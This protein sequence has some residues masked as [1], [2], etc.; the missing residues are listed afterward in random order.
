MSGDFKTA[1]IIVLYYPDAV[2]LAE[3]VEAVLPAAAQVILADNTPPADYTE[4]LPL[5][6]CLRINMGGNAGI[7]A[8]QAEALLLA[9]EIG[10]T[11]V[12]MLDQDSCVQPG[13]LEAME[14]EYQRLEAS[15]AS[16]FALGATIVNSRSGAADKALFDKGKSRADGFTERRQLISSGSLI[17]MVAVRETGLPERGL[18][19]DYVDFEWCWRAAIFGFKCFTTSKV[20]L[21]HTVGC[22]DIE[23]GAYRWVISAPERYFYQFR[24]YF[25]LRRRDYVPMGWKWRTFLRMFFYFTYLP[26]GRRRAMSYWRNMWLGACA[27]LK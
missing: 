2:A 26:W 7:A 9:A 18:F 13:F 8:A 1:V 17:N 19:I 10:A 25:W 23:A 6:G 15:G 14:R 5:P 11:H 16:I 27:G 4:H 24:N 3:T 12:L 20:E 22:G 21:E